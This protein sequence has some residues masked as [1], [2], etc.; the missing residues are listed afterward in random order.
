MNREMVDEWCERG[1][2][3]VA[4]AMLCL[5]P[6]AFG[7]RPQPATGSFLDPIL[8]DP[9]TVAEWLTLPLVG[10]WLVR[11]WMN[12]KARLLWPPI[13][14]AVL[15]FTAYAVARY[16][17]AEL[18]YI[19]RLEVLK[20]LVYAVVFFVLL[21]NLQGKDMIRIVSFTLIFLAMAI[22]FY[23]IYQFLRPTDRVWHLHSGAHGRASG[24]YISPNH[25]AGFL[26]MLLPLGLAYTLMGR[27]K[28]MMKVALGY[29]SLI[30]LAGLATTVS[31]GSWLAT[32][33]AMLFFFGVLMF[34]RTFRLPAVACLAV[35]L[36][37]GGVF[38]VKSN[39]MQGRLRGLVNK[40]GEVDDDMRF[41]LWRP[42]IRVWKDNIW[43][44][45]GPAHYDA[46]F[47]PYRPEEVQRRPDRAHNDFLN[48]LADWGIVGT[49]LVAAAWGFLG[50]GVWKMWGYV[51]R[52]PADIGGKS[53]NSKFA[54]VLGSCTGLLAL[55]FHSGVDFN[56]HI[57][58]NALL[59]VSLMA[60]LSSNLRFSTE[61]Y[62]HTAGV[63]VKVPLTLCLLA[64]AVYLGT[65]AL[66]EERQNY[67]LAKANLTPEAASTPKLEL[68]K[69]AF[70][71]EPMN[72][73]TARDIGEILRLQS[74]DAQQDQV[75]AQSALDWFRKSLSLNHWDCDSW[76]GAGWCLD[77]L[78]QTKESEVCFT[79]AEEVDP[80]SYYTAAKIGAHYIKLEEYAAARPWCERSLRLE[81]QNNTMP[82]NYL[83]L[84]NRRLLE[85]ATNDLAAALLK[86]A[87][88]KRAEPAPK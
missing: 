29:A 58:A 24:T 32:A 81:W 59:A 53:T 2:L 87:R 4:L 15:A 1:I 78:D 43:F 72:G 86:S 60:L 28:P 88:T 76:L 23:A 55:F 16:L 44:G 66:R 65:Q 56:M 8:L 20:V 74:V 57:P 69:Q 22:S 61:K 52:T 25:L 47:R 85:A 7:A 3:G 17:T 54:F 19:A 11:I 13:C 73:E 9:F 67:W 48:T 63:L 79:H 64:A 30:I 82:K 21:N 33:L 40:Q 27:E 84:A 39:A 51:R 35:I 6:L 70:T 38:L 41:S 80:N 26:E 10:L 46:H 77:W 34:D 49:A 18:E 62:W 50:Y 12:P 68:L 14:W 83:E 71:V 31:R 36:V 75:L 45:A 37:T 42:A 5:M